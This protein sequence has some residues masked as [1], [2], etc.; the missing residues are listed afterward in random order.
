MMFSSHLAHNGNRLITHQPARRT[1]PA[2]SRDNPAICAPQRPGIDKNQLAGLAQRDPASPAALP[3]A[4]WPV[5]S[6]LC[7]QIRQPALSSMVSASR[8]SSPAFSFPS[9]LSRRL[10]AL[11]DI[12]P[13]FH[14]VEC[15]RI[16][17]TPQVQHS[18]RQACFLLIEPPNDPERRK[19]SFAFM[20]RLHW[21]QDRGLD[22][23]ILEAHKGHRAVAK[24]PVM[25]G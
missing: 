21:N 19:R 20:S 12:R 10:W 4:A 9:A 11:H 17:S 5:P 18:R 14:L 6:T 8:R 1:R 22:A 7:R 2:A 3:L 25:P 13:G 24:L 15:R 16:R 23:I